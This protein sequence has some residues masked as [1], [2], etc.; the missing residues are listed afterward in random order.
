MKTD[1]SRL[2]NEHARALATV[3][4]KMS[5]LTSEISAL[6]E[7][8]HH[9]L[10]QIR[11]LTMEITEMKSSAKL[12]R[13]EEQTAA[14]KQEM[15]E[16]ILE[17][18]RE[19]SRL[20]GLARS[21][22]S[23]TVTDR[24][25]SMTRDLDRLDAEKTSAMHAANAK[26]AAQEARLVEGQ[27]SLHAMT[28]DLA[29]ARD[30][31]AAEVDRLRE[32]N[33]ALR[34]QVAE[35]REEN[36]HP[37]VSSSDEEHRRQVYREE[38]AILWQTIEDRNRTVAE[39]RQLLATAHLQESELDVRV[40]REVARCEVIS[41]LLEE[42]HERLLAEREGYGALVVGGGHAPL[43]VE[44]QEKLRRAAAPVPPVYVLVDP[45]PP[46]DFETDNI[47]LKA[48]IADLQS[49]LT[50]SSTRARREG[51]RTPAVPASLGGTP[52]ASSDM[53]SERLKRRLAL[54]E[55]ASD[56]ATDPLLTATLSQ[57]MV[58]LRR[59]LQDLMRGTVSL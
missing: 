56:R 30:M 57:E 9:A 50:C 49:H 29:A 45:P 22:R 55:S 16:R 32:D 2:V 51:M 18:E 13:V 38:V 21:P 28:T 20:S 53:Y 40:R 54:L 44:L 24:L 8:E 25:E 6:T 10:E 42:A 17:L 36:A 33:A 37:V 3:N 14:E 19:V 58:H 4:K 43:I 59:A 39:M 12:S 46:T 47:M 41:L 11:L 52:H 48:V 7:A 27:R 23:V 35:L 15:R 5:E 26:I 1:A 34:R 31:T